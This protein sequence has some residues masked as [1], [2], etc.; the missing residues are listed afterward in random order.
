MYIPGI[1]NFTHLKQTSYYH[2]PPHKI[3]DQPLPTPSLNIRS[4]AVLFP[5][6]SIYKGQIIFKRKRLLVLL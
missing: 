6:H 4:R 5:P 2:L 1:S 3:P